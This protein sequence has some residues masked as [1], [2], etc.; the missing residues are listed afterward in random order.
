MSTD[1]VK[2]QEQRVI[3]EAQELARRHLLGQSDGS[4]AL[5]LTQLLEAVHF[6]GTISHDRDVRRRTLKRRRR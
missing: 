3:R 4:K 5:Q 2:E 6:L 1:R